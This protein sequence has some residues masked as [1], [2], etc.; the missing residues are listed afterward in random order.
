MS[1]QSPLTQREILQPEKSE[2]YV[3]EYIPENTEIDTTADSTSILFSPKRIF[4]RARLWILDYLQKL[5]QTDV[6]PFNMILPYNL[7][8]DDSAWADA[9]LKSLDIAG[10][11]DLEPNNE[12]KELFQRCK[13]TKDILKG[14][15]DWLRYLQGMFETE[16]ERVLKQRKLDSRESIIYGKKDD[17][18]Q[19]RFSSLVNNIAD[20]IAMRLAITPDDHPNYPFFS[21]Q[22]LQE[23]AQKDFTLGAYSNALCSFVVGKMRDIFQFFVLDVEKVELLLQI[24]N[25]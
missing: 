3:P 16:T 6:L 24:N 11:E 12:A 7:P 21:G 2:E 5:K 25:A 4:T 14:L 10:G 18:S 20:S 23:Q 1:Y 19:E 17:S 9:M 15:Q 22:E 13:Y 8:D